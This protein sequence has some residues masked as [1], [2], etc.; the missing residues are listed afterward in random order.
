MES[1]AFLEE[2]GEGERGRLAEEDTRGLGGKREK[3][4]RRVTIQ[5]WW[6]ERAGCQ[7]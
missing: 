2:E 5:S 1:S 6:T 4:R 3:L 7:V